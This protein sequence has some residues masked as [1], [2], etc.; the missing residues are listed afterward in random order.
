M[1]F[2]FTY[3]GMTFAISLES[4]ESDINRYI[5]Y[6][7]KL[8]D[9]NLS[10]V[11]ALQEHILLGEFDFYVLI[12]TY[13]VS[14]FTD[15]YL[16]L[17]ISF[18]F[19]FGFFLS[20]NLLLLLNHSNTKNSFIV[21]LLFLFFFINPIFNINGV[22]YYTALQIFVYGFL[23]YFYS[24]NKRFL[25]LCLCTP[26]VHFSFYLAILFLIVAFLVK[27][28]T[29]LLFYFFIMSVFASELL[30][31]E[32]ISKFFSLFGISFFEERT[33][34]YTDQEIINQYL[35]LN[36]TKVNW[37]IEY[38]NRVL[39]IS[40]NL[41]IILIYYFKRKVLENKAFYENYW[42]ISIAL[43]GIGNF[44]S[45]H[46][47]IGRFY[48]LGVLFILAFLIDF[49]SLEEN[50]D[51]YKRIGFTKMAI[52]IGFS[53]YIFIIFRNGLY[54]MSLSTVLFNPIVS[55]FIEKHISLNDIIKGLN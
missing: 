44:L 31:N 13:F 35:D 39:S 37:Y 41:T 32:S 40:L 22:R 51:F 15:N 55:L 49:L 2:L 54:S 18:A 14:I 47:V 7:N 1:W 53:F 34:G 21:V 43:L 52:M 19:I 11:Q 45:Q 30:N 17:T 38:L 50:K 28:R 27:K 6:L 12:L 24:N 25:L 26:L 23:S 46:F 10:F 5:D 36:T 20:R 9:A 29:H 4:A 8:H 33:I 16:F 48:Y 42:G 3:Y